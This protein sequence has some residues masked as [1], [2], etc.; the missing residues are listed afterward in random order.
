VK[1]LDAAERICRIAFLALDEIER[2]VARDQPGQGR[3]ARKARRQRHR[4]T[5]RPAAA[6]RRREGLVEIE[7]HAVYTE[8]ARPHAPQERVHIG[9]VEIEISARRM[10]RGG[11]LGRLIL[12]ET[13]SVGV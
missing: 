1:R 3:K 7:M 4:P 2:T 9:A 6:M 12:E 5:A 10:N 13:A 8:I 11:D